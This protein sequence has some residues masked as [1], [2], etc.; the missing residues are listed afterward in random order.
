M[1]ARNFAK[2]MDNNMLCYLTYCLGGIKEYL[3]YTVDFLWLIGVTL[4]NALIYIIWQPV[5]LY[6]YLAYIHEYEVKFQKEEHKRF[7]KLKKTGKI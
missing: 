4:W 1:Y 5:R 6:K 2:N 7:V 3:G